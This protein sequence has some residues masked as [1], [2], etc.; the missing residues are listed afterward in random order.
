MERWTGGWNSSRSSLPIGAFDIAIA[1]PLCAVAEGRRPP[2][3]TLQ[4]LP[5]MPPSLARGDIYQLFYERGCQLLKPSRGLLSLHHLQQLA[6]GRIRQV[7][8]AATSRKITRPLLLMEL[9]KDV[10]ESAIVDSGVLMLRTGGSCRAIPRRGHGPGQSRRNSARPR[11]VGP[12]AARR[13]C[14][15]EHPVVH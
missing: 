15:V 11:I 9:G 5:A 7:H 1:N 13:R 10:F 4:G 12:G 6:E 14:A 3:T 2:G 8:C